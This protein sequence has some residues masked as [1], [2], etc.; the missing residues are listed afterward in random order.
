MKL[1]FIVGLLTTHLLAVENVRAYE[2]IAADISSGLLPV[3][4]ARHAND[5]NADAGKVVQQL[6]NANVDVVKA[7]QTV[8][9]EWSTCEDTYTSVRKGVQIAPKRADEIVAAIATMRGCRCNAQSFWARTKLE[10][11]LRPR[12][13]RALVEI[14]S[15]CSCASAGIEAAIEIVPDQAEDMIDA[16]IV[17]KNR[18]ARTVDS[19][20]QI[21]TVPTQRYWGNDPVVTKDTNLVR[22]IGVCKGDNNEMDEFS[23]E[24]TWKN[25]DSITSYNE[26]LGQHK[27]D[28]KEES[29]ESADTGKDVSNTDSK[30]IISQYIE[31]H[32]SNQALELYN[33]SDAEIDLLMDNYQLEVYFHG[34]D[35]PGTVIQLK[36]LIAPQSTFVVAGAGAAVDITALANQKVNGLIFK[37][38]DAVV[39]KTGFYTRPCECAVAT[40]AAAINGIDKDTKPMS[41]DKKDFIKRIEQHY[42]NT[43]VQATIVDSIG[44]IL[45]N[46]EL[47]NI[48]KDR[49][50]VTDKTLRRV[51]DTCKGD[52]ITMDEF[53]I[54]QEWKSYAVDNFLDSGNY[55]EQDCLASRKDLLLS[56]YIEGSNNNAMIE[57]YNGTD[58][59]VNFTSERYFLEIHN[60]D[61]K[62]SEHRIYLKGQVQRNGVFVISHSDAEKALK[63]VSHQTSGELTLG[64]TRAVV[65]KKVVLPAYKACYADITSWVL[66]NNLD[67][68][69]YT[70]T[71]IFDPGIGPISID[72]P[73]DGDD[74]GELASPN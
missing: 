32:G 15:A 50:I 49:P 73:R 27:L 23:P 58:R 20:G 68:I 25:A 56:E 63:D 71:P 29:K 13:N 37:G 2:G 54:H 10:Q 48:Q 8:A 7:V 11:R 51:A 17:A 33:G 9:K 45:A 16:V 22:N 24:A 61:D 35:F 69:T 70:L 3:E 53:V 57:I 42:T 62:D 60:D 34:Y 64:N 30:L 44:R 65:L 67:N 14:S 21:G 18:A 59:P 5:N 52:R 47:A 19:I 1:L 66:N 72:D 28:C 40:V 55:D 6:V 74:G 31:G 41:E 43:N 26:T 12:I 4:A 38:A 39:L 46:D 36:G